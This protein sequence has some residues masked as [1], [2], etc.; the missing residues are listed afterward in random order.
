MLHIDTLVV[1][2]FQSNCFIVRRPESAEAIVID[3]GDNAADIRACLDEQGLTVKAY[4]LTH[5]HVDHVF[6]LAEMVAVRP[7]P[8]ALHPD[9]ARWAFTERAAIPPY[10]GTP[11]APPT[12]DRQLADGQIWTD[13]GLTYHI[14][15]LPGHSPGGVAF[16]FESEKTLFSGDTLFRG[17]VG[18][19][20]LP[21]SNPS[22]LATSLKK[23]LTLPDDT[24]VHCGHGP[25]TTI[26]R[27][28]RQN[29]F[30][31][32]FDWAS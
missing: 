23:L 6:A 3:P 13:L 5:G 32:T 2:L 7:A 1:S 25:A 12:I 20:D 27:E 16:Y 21:G 31:K 18:R 4:L 28:R 30:L 14:F 24:I 29:P 26:G 15:H 19:S 9:D 11:Q 22:A 8:V 17:S 10:Y